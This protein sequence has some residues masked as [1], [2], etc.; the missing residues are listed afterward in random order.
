MF[1][2]AQYEA[3]LRALGRRLTEG[4]RRMLAA[5]ASAPG[6][7]LDVVELAQAAGQS[8]D[9][10][11][12]SQYGSLGHMIAT[13]I[14]PNIQEVVWTRVIGHDS[15]HAE[16]GRVQWRM[17]PPLL[18]TVQSLRWDGQFSISVPQQTD[19]DLMS[20]GPTAQTALVEIRLTQ[21]TF[22]TQLV[23][24]WGGCAVTGCTVLE[25]L[26]ASH[27]KP[28]SESSNEERRDSFNELLLLGTLDR[29]FDSGRISFGDDGGIRISELV[30]GTAQKQL[31][32]S[33][34]LRLRRIEDRHL[35]YLRWHRDHVFVPDV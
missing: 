32:I 6:G 4:Q 1:T 13:L 31:H 9:N 10:F 22:R 7:V 30:S 15:R 3:A 29:L 2:E 34:S 33:P 16:S 18:S 21:A 11:T 19:D 28:W 27:I 24:Y 12:Y 25:A 14:D 35:P 17:H 8:S 20:L 26:T 23:R 5:H